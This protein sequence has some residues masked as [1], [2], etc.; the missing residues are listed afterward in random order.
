MLATGHSL[1]H[2]MG[3]VDGGVSEQVAL[4]ASPI[5]RNSTLSSRTF[6]P[7]S[8]EQ[9]CVMVTTTRC[10]CP[11]FPICSANQG[12]KEYLEALT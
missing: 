2:A 5:N 7:I 10:D 6:M 8:S 11:M 1:A 12:R 4:V 3:G 9:C